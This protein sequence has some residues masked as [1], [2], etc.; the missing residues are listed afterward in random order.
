MKK[1]THSCYSSSMCLFRDLSRGLCFSLSF[2]RL[3]PLGY[4]L[5][6]LSGGSETWVRFDYINCNSFDSCF[7]FYFWK[8]ICSNEL[9]CCSDSSMFRSFS[10]EEHCCSDSVIVKRFCHNC[11]SDSFVGKLRNFYSSILFVFRVEEKNYFFSIYWNAY[12]VVGWQVTCS[13]GYTG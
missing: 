2:R 10:V 9:Y 5:Q 8:E 13:H 11:C 1:I 6:W 7:T 12:P 4:Q 3:W